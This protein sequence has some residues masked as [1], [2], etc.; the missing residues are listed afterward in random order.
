MLALTA[1]IYLA[2]LIHFVRGDSMAAQ[3]PR[4]FWA[5]LALWPGPWAIGAVFSLLKRM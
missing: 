3:D 2:G 4:R 1:S 5:V